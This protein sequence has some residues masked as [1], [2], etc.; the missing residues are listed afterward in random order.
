MLSLLTTMVKVP[1]RKLPYLWINEQLGDAYAKTA[2]GLCKVDTSLRL[3]VLVTVALTI[4]GAKEDWVVD[5][6]GKT[7]LG[8]DWAKVK[9]HLMQVMWIEIIHDKPGEIVFQELENLRLV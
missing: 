2:G 8:L 9:N 3:W 1:G 7:E 4:T 5:A 6:W